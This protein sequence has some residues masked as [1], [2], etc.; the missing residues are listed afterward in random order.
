[1]LQG[2]FQKA[3]PETS[4]ASAFGQGHAGTEGQVQPKNFPVS[5]QGKKPL[6][7]APDPCQRSQDT[8]VS[9]EGDSGGPTLT[10]PP[11]R[12][13]CK[14]LDSVSGIRCAPGHLGGGAG[15]RVIARCA[16]VGGVWGLVARGG[17]RARW[18]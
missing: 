14:W 2:L 9:P 10:P 4:P 6:Q 18:V 11:P 17:G 12:A 16:N 15:P 7:R 8:R 5:L 13:W 1:M 3:V